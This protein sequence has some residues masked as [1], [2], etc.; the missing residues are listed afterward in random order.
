[1]FHA[2]VLLPKHDHFEP[3]LFISVLLSLYKNNFTAGEV[4]KMCVLF[5][6]PAPGLKR[7]RLCFIASGVFNKSSCSLILYKTL[8][9]L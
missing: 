9:C 2:V 4:C 1:M 6:T 8:F 7:P 5:C 3:N